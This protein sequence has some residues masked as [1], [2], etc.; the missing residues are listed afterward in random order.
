MLNTRKMS[1]LMLPEE[2]AVQH[3]ELQP[4]FNMFYIYLLKDT[5]HLCYY[6]GFILG[7]FPLWQTSD[8]FFIGYSFTLL[9]NTYW[10]N[11]LVPL[12]P[13]WVSRFLNREISFAECKHLMYLSSIFTHCNAA[14]GEGL[15]HNTI[16]FP[17]RPI[18]CGSQHCRAKVPTYICLQNC[19]IEEFL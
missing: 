9:I 13:F 14:K 7:W 19:F 3:W 12:N 15:F 17:S 5:M 10:T 11:L 1:I 2:Q 4:H 18:F 16:F 6:I 8:T